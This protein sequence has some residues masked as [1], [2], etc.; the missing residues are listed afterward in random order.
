MKLFPLN[1]LKRQ[2]LFWDREDSAEP[3]QGIAVSHS[4]PLPVS[5]ILKDSPNL[6]AF[7]RLRVSNPQTL[8]DSK[9]IFNDPGIADN[10]ENQPLFFDNQ[11]VSGG[12]TS[13][14][15][16]NNQASQTIT[17]D[18]IVLAVR[19]IGGSTNVDVEGSLTWREIV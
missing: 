6:D 4:Y 5:A 18:S 10:L 7:G 8:F 1:E 16:N 14:N 17:V 9:N 15:Y 12:G 13:T 11:E 19:P 2:L 3:K